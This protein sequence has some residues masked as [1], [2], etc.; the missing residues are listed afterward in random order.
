MARSPEEM[1]PAAR[2][3]VG[4]A[5]AALGTT[6]VAMGAGLIPVDP[7]SV[8]APAWV[9]H[10]LGGLFALVGLWIATAGTPVGEVLKHVVGPASLF[11]LLAVLHWIAFGPGVRR[12]SGGLA[13]PFVSTWGSVGDLEC[14]I[15]FGYGALLFDG[16]ILGAT[17]SAWAERQE[18][19][20]TRRI[21]AGLSNVL[22]LVPLLPF[23]VLLFGFGL[24]KAAWGNVRGG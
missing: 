18:A 10:T 6:V 2:L 17:L 22:I 23:L 1:S 12:C 14:R 24:V 19:G 16:L 4:G 9:I 21:A 15:A 5:T 8:Y 3:L 7:A 20:M 11:G 13:L